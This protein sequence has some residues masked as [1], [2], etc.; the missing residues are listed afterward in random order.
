MSL[1]YL[2]I[3][4]Q[5]YKSTEYEFEARVNLRSYTYD[6]INDVEMV[7]IRGRPGC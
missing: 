1:L 7:K 6:I 4:P 5:V 3:E 2:K